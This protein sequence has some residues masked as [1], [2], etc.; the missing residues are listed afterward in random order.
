[1]SLKS[2]VA[3]SLALEAEVAREKASGLG[4]TGARLEHAL[5]LA[6]A[7]YAQLARLGGRATPAQLA[8]YADA[9]AE[10]EKWRWYL[11]VQREAM[12]LYRHDDVEAIYVLPPKLRAP[13]PAPPAE[14]SAP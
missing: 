13:A 11:V 7:L 8:E 2:V 3:T 1:M 12:G 5:A 14:A 9:R 4:R 6:Q 10:A